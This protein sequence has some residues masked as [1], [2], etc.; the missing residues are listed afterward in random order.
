M[1]LFVKVTRSVK[2]GR[3]V[4][5]TL[6]LA[7]CACVAWSQQS[8]PP[9]P[10]ERLERAQARVD[11][12]NKRV[13]DALQMIAEGEA[14]RKNGQAEVK[15]YTKQLKQREKEHMQEAKML[16]GRAS[17]DDKEEKANAREELKGMQESFRRDSK[18]IKGSLKGAMKEKR[19][20]DKLVDR[21]EKK[22]K[23][24]KIF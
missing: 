3:V 17:T 10:Q 24:A 8:T 20:G 4:G 1:G 18:E 9:T 14:M 16:L 5:L 21:G 7:C 13:Q 22:L 12:G 19:N 6:V 11:E 15:S 23:K 2:V